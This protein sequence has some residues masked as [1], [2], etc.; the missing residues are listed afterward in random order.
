M[1]WMRDEIKP[2]WVD[3]DREENIY[4]GSPRGRWGEDKRSEMAD[5]GRVTV[6]R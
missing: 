4:G 3:C 5:G 1:I 2:S 6:E